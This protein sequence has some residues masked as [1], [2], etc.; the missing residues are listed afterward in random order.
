MVSRIVSVLYGL[1]SHA[2]EA[3]CNS[4]TGNTIARMQPSSASAGEPAKSKERHGGGDA[5]AQCRVS[6]VMPGQEGSF[7]SRGATPCCKSDRTKRPI[8]CYSGLLRRSLFS[9]QSESSHLSIIDPPD[10]NDALKANFPLW[11]A[12]YRC[13]YLAAG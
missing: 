1:A 11:A 6:V 4:S 7:P 5:I 8:R 13:M 10:C 3:A 2:A 9:I 12:R